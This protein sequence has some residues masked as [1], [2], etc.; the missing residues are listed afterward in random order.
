[1]IVVVCIRTTLKVPAMEKKLCEFVDQHGL[2][3]TAQLLGLKPPSVHLAVKSGRDIRVVT[4]K[5]G[6]P[7]TAYEIRPF[8]SP[9]AKKRT[10]SL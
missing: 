4:A 6:N 1:M 8:P 10:A 3:K 7:V 9:D 2:T 5:G